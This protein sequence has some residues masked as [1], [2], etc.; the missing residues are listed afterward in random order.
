MPGPARLASLAARG[1]RR[2]VQEQL[3]EGESIPS[4]L[5][6]AEAVRKVGDGQRIAGARQVAAGAKLRRQ[7]LERVARQ[8]P[9]TCHA[10]SRSRWARSRSEAGWT[11][12]MPGRVESRRGAARPL[13][14][15]SPAGRNSCASTR[16]PERS[17]FPYSKQP[18]P[19]LQALGQPGLVEPDRLRRAR[20]VGHGRLDDHQAAAASPPQ[21][22]RAHLDLDR[23]LLADP[24]LRQ[25]ARRGEVP[26]GVRDVQ[27]QL[28]EGLDPELG[29]RRRQPGAGAAK[30][31]QRGPEH[32]RAGRRAKRRRA[33]GARGPAALVCEGDRS[34]GLRRAWGLTRRRRRTAHRPKATAA[35]GRNPA[36]SLG[37][38][39]ARA[40]ASSVSLT[41]PVGLMFWLSR[42]R[43]V[44]S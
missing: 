4:P 42:N 29:R 38:A 17:S 10:H 21:A 39:Q 3:L 11:G 34:R 18:R 8:R 43:L 22:H 25:P 6:L 28:A 32:A 9:R 30:R 35:R 41:C 44:G 37:A 12:T 36:G 23:R 20:L 7:R 5:G 13:R 15:P 1:E 24:K 26:V 19:G 33:Q 27:Q 2:L 40:A 14:G 31:G 16:K